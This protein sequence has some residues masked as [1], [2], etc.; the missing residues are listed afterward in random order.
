MCFKAICS[1]FTNLL[2]KSI[3]QNCTSMDNLSHFFSDYNLYTTHYL[4]LITAFF[5]NIYF[6]MDVLKS[7]IENVS[8]NL[9]YHCK[10]IIK[11]WIKIA[12]YIHHKN[13]ALPV[14]NI[15]I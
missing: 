14:V 9:F 6:N 7:I 4:S 15:A 11:H 8:K 13:T 1:I 2:K 12:E 10:R 5:Q 3:I